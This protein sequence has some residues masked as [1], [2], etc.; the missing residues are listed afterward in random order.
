MSPLIIGGIIVL[1]MLLGIIWYDHNQ[2][3]R[4]VDRIT[5]QSQLL[6]A[7]K[8][9]VPIDMPKSVVLLDVFGNPIPFGVDEAN[10]V[11]LVHPEYV[12]SIV[13]TLPVAQPIHGNISTLGN[14]GGSLGGWLHPGGTVSYD[15]GSLRPGYMSYFARIVQTIKR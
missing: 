2:A 12:K 11:H 14:T 15:I 3:S 4:R 9:L 7:N 1:V 8:K 13:I 5:L 10:R 6:D